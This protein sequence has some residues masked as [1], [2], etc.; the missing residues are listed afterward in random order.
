[1]CALTLLLIGVRVLYQITPPG[2]VAHLIANLGSISSTST[3]GGK[4]NVP[5]T[6]K[7]FEHVIGIWWRWM[8]LSGILTA[9][10]LF[11]AIMATILAVSLC[12]DPDNIAIPIV[13]VAMDIFGKWSILYFFPFIGVVGP[14]P[15]QSFF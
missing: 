15:V 5:N 1:M 12:V 2:S 9:S 13:S 8:A 6:I 11:W 7:S 14:V 10:A 4:S 3:V